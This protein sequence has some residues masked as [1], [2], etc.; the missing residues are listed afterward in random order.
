MALGAGFRFEDLLA[1]AGIEFDG[2][3][4]QSGRRQEN[5]Q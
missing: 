2:G 5:E 1:A 3:G 4:A